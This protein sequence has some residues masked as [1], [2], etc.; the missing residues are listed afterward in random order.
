[1]RKFH[2]TMKNNFSATIMFVLLE[3]FSFG[4]FLIHVKQKGSSE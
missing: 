1:M 3:G 2:K 4:E